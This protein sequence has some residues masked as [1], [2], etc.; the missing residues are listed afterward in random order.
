MDVLVEDPRSQGFRRLP[1]VLPTII[2]T[3][4]TRVVATAGTILLVPFARV[5]DVV[6]IV[7]VANAVVDGWALVPHLLWFR[8]DQ[9]FLLAWRRRCRLVE[10]RPALPGC[11][12]FGLLHRSALEKG[13]QLLMGLPPLRS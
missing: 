8:V 5:E 12:A 4:S 11:G 13:T 9:S 6:R 3:A 7:V 2:A 1:L 10:L